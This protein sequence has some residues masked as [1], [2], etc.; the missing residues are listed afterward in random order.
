MVYF[1]QYIIMD[2]CDNLISKVA[3]HF[4][5]IMA[6][7]MNKEEMKMIIH[8]KLLSPLLNMIYTEV[9]PYIYGLFI[10]I[11]LIF[12]LSLLTFILFVFSRIRKPLSI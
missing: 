3:N 11:F 2:K 6:D 8:K 4:I 10:T 12:I 1:T 7:E 5:D 9:Y